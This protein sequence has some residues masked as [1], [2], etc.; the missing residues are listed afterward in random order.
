MK[1]PWGIIILFSPLLSMFENWYSKFKTKNMKRDQWQRKHSPRNKAQ[2]MVLG[3]RTGFC[4]L[5][6]EKIN[7]GRVPRLGQ[8]GGKAVKEGEEGLAQWPP[9]S[10]QRKGRT[11]LPTMEETG[12]WDWSLR[13]DRTFMVPER[14]NH[15]RKSLCSEH[16]GLGGCLTVR[17]H[18][19]SGQFW[20]VPKGETVILFL[21]CSVP[22]TKRWT[23]WGLWNSVWTS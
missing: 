12:H 17:S 20:A 3:H 6:Q 16:W 11:W 7:K 2:R 18:G 23:V 19:R 4:L 15:G 1:G 14:T 5:E 9:N 22:P 8:G 21:G 13:R 10:P